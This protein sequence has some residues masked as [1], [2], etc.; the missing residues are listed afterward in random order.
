MNKLLTLKITLGLVLLIL[1]SLLAFGYSPQE[2]NEN[3]TQKTIIE[4]VEVRDNTSKPNAY[5]GFFTKEAIVNRGDTLLKILP[6]LSINDSNLEKY[7]LNSKEHK[8]NLKLHIGDSVRAT[9][10]QNGHFSKITLIRSRGIP[11]DI[12]KAGNEFKISETKFDKRL[13]FGSG[14]VRSSL[15]R[16]LEENNISEEVALKM[17]DIFSSEIDFNRDIRQGDHFSVVYVA[18]FIGDTFISTGHIVAAEFSNNGTRHHAYYFVNQETKKP[19]YYDEDGRNIKKSFLRSPLKFSRITSGFSKGRLHPVLKKW[20]A[21]KGLDFG[22]PTGTPI[23]ATGRGKVAYIGRKGGYGRLIEIRHAN[24]ISTRYAHLSRYV[25]KLKKNSQVEQGQVIG[26]VG[27]SGLATGPHLHYEFLKNGTQVNPA[28]AVLPPGKS[29][30]KKQKQ[31]FKKHIAPATK[32][33]NAL[34]R[35]VALLRDY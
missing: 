25:R 14:V 6:K 19:G 32:L 33:L 17:A 4:H 30:N 28:K 1:G 11:I 7:L 23:M 31:A 27:Q 21:H 8:K 2:R 24:G 9:V 22:A 18:N 16:A 15:Y 35:N 26:Y 29:L 3:H 10:D 34:G 20:R 12:S 5:L 13:M